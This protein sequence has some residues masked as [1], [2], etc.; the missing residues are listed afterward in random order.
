MNQFFRSY[1]FVKLDNYE[2]DNVDILTTPGTVRFLWWNGKPGIVREKEIEAIK[3][4]LNDYKD[5]ENKR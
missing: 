5:A 3:S 4:F 2:L 1:I